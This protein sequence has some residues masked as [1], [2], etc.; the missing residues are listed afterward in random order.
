MSRSIANATEP[1]INHLGHRHLAA[2][3]RLDQGKNLRQA[4]NLPAA[5]K[6]GGR[7]K[8]NVSTVAGCRRLAQIGC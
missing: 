6:P 1:S 2:D 3:L 7:V 5:A 8:T 4:K